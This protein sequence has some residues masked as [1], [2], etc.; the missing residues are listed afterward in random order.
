[1]SEGDIRC[2]VASS[3]AARGAAVGPDSPAAILTDRVRP[4]IDSPDEEMQETEALD[5]LVQVEIVVSRGD[6]S[7][8]V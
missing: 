4:P 5:D 3:A 1:M 8:T 2:A 6:I 7:G